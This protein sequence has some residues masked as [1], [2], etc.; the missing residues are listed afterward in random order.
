MLH[1]DPC[2]PTSQTISLESLS[3]P[4]GCYA[5]EEPTTGLMHCRGKDSFA[6]IL[7]PT[8]RMLCYA[9]V[10]LRMSRRAYRLWNHSAQRAK[11]KEKHEHANT[12]V[13]PS[14]TLIS[15]YPGLFSLG[16]ENPSF[17]AFSLFYS[18][19][20]YKSVFF[21]HQEQRSKRPK[22]GHI[23]RRCGPNMR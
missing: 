15:G 18:E 21:G 12:C 1:F 4:P 3:L 9:K 17:Y 13:F 2:M 20:T 11:A 22:T 6:G 14:E 7:E 8:A 5:Y 16:F 23:R 10:Q 19:F